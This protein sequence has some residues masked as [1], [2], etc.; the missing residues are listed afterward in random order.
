M[1]ITELIRK[2]QELKS[3]FGD[4][5]VGYSVNG[6]DMGKY[7]NNINKVMYAKD[8]YFHRYIIALA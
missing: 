4:L 8:D 1:T 6:H 5:N 3:E 2:L 7:Y